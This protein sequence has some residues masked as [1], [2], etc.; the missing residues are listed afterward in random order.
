MITKLLLLAKQNALLLLLGYALTIT[1]L[2]LLSIGNLPEEAPEFSDKIIHAVAYAIFTALFYNY[3]RQSDKKSIIVL[4]LIVPFLFGA[5]IEVLQYV[6]NPDRTFDLWDIV[7]NGIGTVIAVV[8]IR[9]ITT[10][11]N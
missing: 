3:I 10:K 11:L 9:T 2:S 6:F 4:T 5:I 8:F 1:A 7:A